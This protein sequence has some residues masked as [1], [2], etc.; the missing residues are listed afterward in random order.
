M[1]VADYF[2]G[3]TARRYPVSV[4]VQNDT[5]VV[6]GEF[7]ERVEP[8]SQIQLSEPM[9]DAPRTIRF[10]DGAL[11]EIA[12]GALTELLPAN[13]VRESWVVRLQSRWR[14]ALSS[15]LAVGLMVAA[16]YVWVLPWLAFTLA[17]QVP[18]VFVRTISQLAIESLDQDMMGTS[19]LSQNRQESISVHVDKLD[20]SVDGLPVHSLLFRS[21]PRIGANAFALP[22][23]DI[24]ITDE[25]VALT[26]NDDEIAAV[27][28]HEL[29]HVKNHHGMRQ[30]IQGT[31]VSFVAASYFGDTSSIV[32]GLGALVLESRYS[33][34]FESEADAFAGERLVK[35]K[36]TA[37]PLAHMLSLIEKSHFKLK[38]SKDE[39]ST[40][41]ADVLS[42]HPDTEARII[43][44]RAMA[45]K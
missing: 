36:G 8:L 5:L 29:G 40:S 26:D 42:S 12:S 10:S 45:K 35:S 9:G 11:C 22:S 34:E 17:P 31:L 24:I 32:A 2:D 43:A 21:S 37:E 19:K 30:L 25:L 14:W 1:P 20:S 27:I 44:L 16:S 3:K 13:V 7:G 18:E 38:L 23:G 15:L 4:A 28:A 33:R 39:N 6:T 41:I